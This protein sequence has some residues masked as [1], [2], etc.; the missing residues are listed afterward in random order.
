MAIGPIAAVLV[1]GAAAPQ[2]PDAFAADN[3]RVWLAA[4]ERYAPG[5]ADAA[6]IKIG[7]WP[8]DHTLATLNDFVALVRGR[9]D[10]QSRLA[11]GITP[12][13]RIW[14]A[15]GSGAPR[16]STRSGDSR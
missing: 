16:C 6:V 15:T 2:K 1:T 5:Q 8:I 11:F 13:P 7:S 10:A 4:V 14:R 3:L 9:R 12:S